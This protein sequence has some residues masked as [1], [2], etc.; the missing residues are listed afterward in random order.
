MKNKQC[1]GNCF[2]G[3]KYTSSHKHRIRCNYKI[4]EIELPDLPEWAIFGLLEECYNNSILPGEGKNCPCW[5]KT[6]A[7]L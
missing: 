4:P 3:E 1:C 2:Y 7:Y 5:K 6:I